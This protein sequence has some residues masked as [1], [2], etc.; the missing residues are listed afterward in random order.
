MSLRGKMYYQE[1]DSLRRCWVWQFFIPSVI[2]SSTC[3]VERGLLYCKVQEIRKISSVNETSEIQLATSKHLHPSPKMVDQ[4]YLKMGNSLT[5]SQH[6]AGLWAYPPPFWTVMAY[7]FLGSP[8]AL[9]Y[10][11]L[12]YVQA[13]CGV[14]VETR[15]G[16]MELVCKTKEQKVRSTGVS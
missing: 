9:P 1:R 11:G 13:R 10:K 8:Y 6:L 7:L 15:N 12:W 4:L 16:W 14:K 2:L 5:L 3:L